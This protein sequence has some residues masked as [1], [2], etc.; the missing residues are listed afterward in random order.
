M[1]RYV[2]IDATGTVYG[3]VFATGA[4]PAIPGQQVVQSD[5]AG[6]GDVYADGVFSAPAQD[7]D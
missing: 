6:A 4:P 5:T 2:L 3:V 7:G 1:D